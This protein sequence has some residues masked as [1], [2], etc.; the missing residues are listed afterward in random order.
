MLQTK[1]PI[2][3]W[4]STRHHPVR[5]GEPSIAVTARITA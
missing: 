3:V 2:R 5:R 1:T 4:I